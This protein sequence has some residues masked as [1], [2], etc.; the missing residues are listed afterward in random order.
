MPVALWLLAVLPAGLAVVLLGRFHPD[1]VYQYLEPA[2]AR[3]FGYGVLAWEW[4]K[5]IRNWAFPG[6]LAGL[7][8]VCR[9]LGITYPIAYRAVLAIPQAITHVFA[10]AT[11]FR[12]YKGRLQEQRQAPWAA[13]IFAAGGMTLILAG[14]TL[15]E[16]LSADLLVLGACFLWR[17]ATRRDAALAG[18]LLM[19]ACVVRYGSAA[20]VAGAGLSLVFQH[21]WRDVAWCVLGGVPVIIALGVLDATTWGAPFH[22]AMAYW[23]FNVSSGDA[24]RHFG[25]MPLSFFA[26]PMLLWMPFWVWAVGA[27]LVR[28]RRPPA[29][30]EPLWMALAYVFALAFVSH[31]EERFLYPAVV[32]LTAALA[33]EV[34]AM[35][36]QRLWARVVAVVASFATLW[37]TPEL[38]SEQF[39][40]TVAVGRDERSTGL[41]IVNEGVWGS[42]GFFYLGRKMPWLNADWPSDRTFQHAVRNPSFNRAITFEGRCLSELK[43]AGFREQWRL[44]RETLL[45][46]GD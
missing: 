6:L 11:L 33:P 7:L 41:L 13:A 12:L 1:E 38:R 10:V 14:R 37:A 3:V 22:S 29:F 16:A 24:A 19:S 25:A 30:V 8:S 23:K 39:Y 20:A 43:A 45:V 46:R 32:L 15:G 17:G 36:G 9:S 18:A 42:G 34:V 44:G 40:A 26:K 4:E 2:Y 21:R 28:H 27:W 5:G 35:A 31:K